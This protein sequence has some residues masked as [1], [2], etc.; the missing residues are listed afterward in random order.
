MS[1]TQKLTA[2]ARLVLRAGLDAAGTIV[3]LGREIVGR[4]VPH[5]SDSRRQAPGP[6][7]PQTPSHPTPTRSVGIPSR[8]AGQPAAPAPTP[9]VAPTPT[10]ATTVTDD[11]EQPEFQP[12]HIEE[13]AATL[14]YSSADEGAQDGAGPTLHIAEP[15]NGYRGMNAPD[16][17]DRLAVADTATLAAVQLFES[18]NRSRKSV[19]AAVD[20]RLAA[21]S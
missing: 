7:S 5:T 1:V 9:P 12:A 15:W 2:P 6:A 14:V 8:P 16:V 19:L 20:H 11:A 18:A 17:V 21:M 4:A 10:P 13:E 3:G